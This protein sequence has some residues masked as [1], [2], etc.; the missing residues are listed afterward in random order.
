[1]KLVTKWLQKNPKITLHGLE[2]MGFLRFLQA[3]YAGKGIK[4]VWHEDY[5]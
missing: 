2:D 1:M 3:C 5:C 4:E